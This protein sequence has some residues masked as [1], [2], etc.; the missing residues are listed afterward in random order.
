MTIVM[1]TLFMDILY[2]R[3][4]NLKNIYLQFYPHPQTMRTL[5]CNRAFG[6][7]FLDKSVYKFF[8]HSFIHHS[9]TQPLHLIYTDGKKGA[10][11][12]PPTPI[13]T[14]PS[15]APPSVTHFPLS[16]PV[17]MYVHWNYSMKSF[18]T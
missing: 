8:I 10:Y 15:L 3:M 14:Q 4:I 9:F 18:K 7:F 5:P 1:M 6:S 2:I 11:T 16:H 17:S 13:S 12:Y